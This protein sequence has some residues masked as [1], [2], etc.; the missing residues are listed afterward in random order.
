[1]TDRLMVDGTP[2]ATPLEPE[3]RE[4]LKYPHVTTRSQLDELEQTNIESGLQWLARRRRRADVL[5]DT[6]MREL[7]RQL[8]GEVWRWAGTFRQTEKN[9]GVDPLQI[10]V[11]LRNLLDDAGL[12]AEHGT[13][14]PLEAAA[15]FHQRLTWIHPFPNGNGRHARIAT[16]LYLEARFGQI[17]IAWAD[18]LQ[19]NSGERQAYLEAVRTADTGDYEPLIRYMAARQ[20]A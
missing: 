14:K 20:P 5:T 7:H 2:G 4:G 9:I 19:V 15:R 6:F 12:W 17:P 13:F 16:D 18:G 11:Q 10:A 8:F 1:M 3:E